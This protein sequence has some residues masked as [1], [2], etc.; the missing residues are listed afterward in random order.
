MRLVVLALQGRIVPMEITINLLKNAM[1]ASKADR[2]L[3]DGFPRQM[4]Q[5]LKFEE[6]VRAPID[7]SPPCRAGGPRTV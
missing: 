3:I 7:A 1:E 6:T 4:D 2:F 5:A